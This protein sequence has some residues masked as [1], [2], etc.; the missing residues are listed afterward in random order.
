MAL[1]LLLEYWNHRCEP[2]WDVNEL[3]AKVQNAADYGTGTLGGDTPQALFG[4]VHVP[5]PEYETTATGQGVYTFGN[6]LPLS[7]IQPRP[8]VLHR[9]LMLRHVSA[10][11]AAGASGKSTLMLLIAAHLALGHDFLGFKCERPGKSII[12]NAEDD[13]EEQ[14]RRLYAL[15]VLYGFDPAQVIPHVCLLSSD[16]VPLNLVGGRE[17]PELNKE[18]IA[19]LLQAASDPDV[20]FCGFD[21]LVELHTRDENS[22]PDMRYVM[23]ILRQLAQRSNSAVMVA[24]HTRKAS[25]AGSNGYA[26]VADSARGS[27]AILNSARMGLTLYSADARDCERYGI[28][29]PDRHRYV[30]LDDAKG[31]MILSNG[32]PVWL[33]KHEV[34]LHNGDAV[35]VLKRANMAEDAAAVAQMIARTLFIQMQGL[36]QASLPMSQAIALLQNCDPLYSQLSIQAVRSRLERMLARPVPCDEKGAALVVARVNGKVELRVQ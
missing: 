8:W 17:T 30:R 10:L 26:G 11:V 12:Y 33:E 1:T 35:G 36:G 31:N 29:E 23:G 14:A 15:C 18:Q 27:G 5:L 22:A 34:R 32:E 25:G 19:P 4:E 2:P 28:A 21:P 24:H 13:R 3:R 6:V 7:S 9:M 16:D 20:V